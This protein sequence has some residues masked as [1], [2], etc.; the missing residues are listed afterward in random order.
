MDLSDNYII[1]IYRRGG[2]NRRML[3][4]VVEEVGKDEK[5]AFTTMEELWDILIG[6]QA[7]QKSAGEEEER[8]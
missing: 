5:R 1:R 4:G 6:D 3:V 2:H 8:R 7:T